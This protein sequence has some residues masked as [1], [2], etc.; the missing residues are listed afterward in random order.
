MYNEPKKEVAQ[1]NLLLSKT[2]LIILTFGNLSVYDRKNGVIA[3]KPS[4]V[5]Y[6]ELTEES[7][8]VLDIDGNVLE[9]NFRPSSDTETHL[10]IYRNFADAN[11][12]IHTH[13]E[14]ATVFAQVRRKIPAYGTTHGDYFYGSVPCTR[15]M[16]PEEIA[17]EYEKNTGKVIVE[18]FAGKDP[19]AV[20]GVLVCSHGPFVW[21]KTSDAALTHAVV[22]EQVAKMAYLTEQ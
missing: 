22:L 19:S 7:I 20:P 21:G 13:S 2:G 12:V 17:S 3:I 1:K 6:D 10:E 5:G 16:T 14:F 11:C 15:E 9:G 8:P 4:G 18:T